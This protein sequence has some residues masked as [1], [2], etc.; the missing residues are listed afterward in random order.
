LINAAVN[1]AAGK[2]FEN[3][4]SYEG[5]SIEFM[6]IDNIHAVRKG[7]EGMTEA[8]ERG[9][10]KW[11]GA[12]EGTGWLRQVRH[13][14]AAAARI[15]HSLA[16]MEQ[17]VL[18]HCSDGWDRTA[19]LTSLSMLL[20]DPYYR[21]LSGFIVLIEKEWLSFGH[22]FGDRSFADSN[23][24]WNDGA[25]RSAVFPLWLDCVHQVLLQHGNAFEFTEELLLFLLRQQWSG[26]FGTFLFNS[27]SERSKLHVR[28]ELVS[29]WTAVL[30][31]DGKGTGSRFVNP[32]YR[33]C[34][35]IVLPASSRPK[36]VIWAALF[37]P[38][39]DRVASSGW[40]NQGLPDAPEGLDLVDGNDTM[41][42]GAGAGGADGGRDARGSGAGHGGIVWVNDKLCHNCHNCRAPFTLF[43]RKHHCRACGQVFC[44]VCCSEQRILI[45]YSGHTTQRCCLP[46][47][48]E[49]DG[50]SDSG[51]GT[52]GLAADS[53]GAC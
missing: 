7:F 4:R 17:S 26:W 34:A 25:E 5:C 51:R 21:T 35:G 45:A 19:Q 6:D 18:V 47:S 37:S 2:G 10:S 11:L 53:G 46:C 31:P 20:I 14:M 42:A 30:W 1:A 9:S 12:V 3:T 52:V 24:G 23:E 38:L 48:R 41:T 39:A 22:R 43:R 32:A 27:E 36:V 13:I 40:L 8:C 29:L 50:Q 16:M 33:P 44:E 15:V 28:A 49:I